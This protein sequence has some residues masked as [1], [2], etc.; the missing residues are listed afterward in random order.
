MSGILVPVP[1]DWTSKDPR[2]RRFYAVSFQNQW[3]QYPDDTIATITSVTCVPSDLLVSG[4][5]AGPG[6]DGAPDQSVG[7]WLTAGS[8]VSP[9]QSRN[10]VVTVA[11]VSLQGQELWRSANLRIQPR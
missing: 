10:Y 3:G 11:I 9:N 8:V 4:Q 2:D 6:T 1:S 7:F 5:I